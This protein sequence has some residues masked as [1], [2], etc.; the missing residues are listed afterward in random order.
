MLLA[1]WHGWKLG[2]PPRTKRIKLELSVL[3]DAR[4][5]DLGQTGDMRS[6]S[7]IILWECYVEEK[8][9]LGVGRALLLQNVIRSRSTN[10]KRKRRTGP[11]MTTRQC[12]PLLLVSQPS[13]STNGGRSARP[14][15]R[16]PISSRAIPCPPNLRRNCS[17]MPYIV[18]GR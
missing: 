12:V 16:Q 10:T 18:R 17:E 2:R 8:Q 7:R 11:A 4:M 1:S 14:R 3:A 9:A 15:K 5:E 13:P 6:S